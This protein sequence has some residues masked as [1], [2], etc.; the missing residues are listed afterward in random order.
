MDKRNILFIVNP[1]SG[2]IRKDRFVRELENAIDKSTFHAEIALTHSA[3][4]TQL[5]AKQAVNAK[6]DVVVACGGDGTINCIAS[7]LTDSH[8]VLGIIPMGSGNGF[9]RALKIPFKLSN[10]LNALQ[11]GDVHQID[12]GKVNE[13]FFIN[14]AGIG[15][16]AHIAGK[17]HDSKRRGLSTYTSLVINEFSR[18][19]PELYR[20]QS[21]ERA[22]ERRSFF[23]AVCNGSQFGN[24]F[25]IA[26]QAD[27]MDGL[28]ELIDVKKPSILQVP[29][30]A[31]N[32][33]QRKFDSNALVSSMQGKSFTIER[34]K[35][36]LVNIDGEPILMGTTLEFRV[37]S[38][39]L[40]VVCC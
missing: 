10:A 27:V 36:G 33:L 29:K 21:D 31:L 37:N 20:V 17:F 13:H 19:Q 5:A 32:A 16:D 22:F 18:Y 24:D 26:P 34:E 14:I 30:L 6:I 35:V 7:Q 39:T 1:V 15:F 25:T 2:G 28:L 40:R 12:T 38:N 8:T 3:S 9:A 23:T 4:D 11:H